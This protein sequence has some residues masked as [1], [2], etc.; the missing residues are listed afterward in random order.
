MKCD[1]M[2]LSQE[3]FSV[4]WIQIDTTVFSTIESCLCL[5]IE[6]EIF[7]VSVKEVHEAYDQQGDYEHV[8]NI[9]MDM[10]KGGENLEVEK[11]QQ[12]LEDENEKSIEGDNLSCHHVTVSANFS[13]QE[14]RRDQ[15]HVICTPAISFSRPKWTV[16]II[17]LDTIITVENNKKKM[18]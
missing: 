16:D 8:T 13:L 14:K 2:T 7:D 3:A 15:N 4:A 9:T 17:G 18:Q 10:E 1:E 6:G 12:G 11:V 5:A